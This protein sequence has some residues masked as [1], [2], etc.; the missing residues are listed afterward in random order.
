MLK[1]R[2]FLFISGLFALTGLIFIVV[3]FSADDWAVFEFH[4]NPDYTM[5]NVG[6]TLT[7]V[8]Y[9]KNS[10]YC[11]SEYDCGFLSLGLW[12]LEICATFPVV[13]YNIRPTSARYYWP[14]KPRAYLYA[15]DKLSYTEKEITN[16]EDSEWKEKKPFDQMFQ[17]IEGLIFI[18]FFIF[19]I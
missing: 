16:P 8:E 17:Y 3:A 6:G 15:C 2:Y 5:K 19:N 1:L 7:G 18:Y 4:T 12:S 13:D 11:K 9:P 10:S 14:K